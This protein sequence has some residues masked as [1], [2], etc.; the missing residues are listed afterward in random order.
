MDFRRIDTVLLDL[1]GTLLDLAFDNDIWLE[2]VPHAWAARHGVAPE[3]ALR[4]LT[5]RFAAV[6]GKLEWYCIDYWSRELGIPVAG[7]HREAAARI[8]WLPGARELLVALRGLGKRLVLLTNAHPETL[9]IK[10]EAT[11]VRGFFDA[12]WSSHAFGA[13]KEDPR[14]WQRVRAVEVFDPARSL[15]VDDSLAVLRAARAAGIAE[16]VAVRRP[17]SSRQRRHHDEF[18][19]VDRV[20]DLLPAIACDAGMGTDTGAAAATG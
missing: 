15:F 1:D 16:V 18:P 3:D 6:E 2:R 9:A 20:A 14:F 12:A 17:D 7:L 10:D 8:A 11:G 13:P 19:A 5:P 4:L